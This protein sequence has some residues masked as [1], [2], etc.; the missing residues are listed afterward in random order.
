MKSSSVFTALALFL[1][2]CAASAQEEV[3][4]KIDIVA[5][6]NDIGGL[7][8]GSGKKKETFTARAFNYSDPVRYSGTRILKLHKSGNGDVKDDYGPISDEDKEHESIPL[9]AAEAAEAVNQEGSIPKKLA[10]LREE[11]PTLVSLIRLPANA[12]RVTI[13]L[14]PAAQGTYIGYVIN[15]DPKK[16]PPGKLRVHNLSPHRIAMQF[17]GGARLEMNARESHL[18]NA[19]QG[20]VIYQL[21]YS[22]DGKWKVQENNIVPVSPNEQTHFIVL[23][24]RNRFFLSSDGATGGYLQMIML[25]RKAEE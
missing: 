23:K 13:L 21:A 18:I 19:P 2:P 24:S 15:D 20:Q 8:L 1:A 17:N 12:R 5:W 25:R 11:D 4:M 22:R 3:S 9:P 6:G 16:L 7:S 14:V 10:K